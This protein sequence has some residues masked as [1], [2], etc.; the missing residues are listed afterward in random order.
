MPGVLKVLNEYY[1]VFLLFHSLINMFLHN[2]F[3]RSIKPRPSEYEHM[4]NQDHQKADV[5][6]H[7]LI[8]QT[9]F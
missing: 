8:F 1:S 5:V 9:S 2:A 7:C 4:N 6:Y 3:N